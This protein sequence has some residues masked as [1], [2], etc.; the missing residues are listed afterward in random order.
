MNNGIILY[1]SKYGATK[2]YAQW[3]TEATG[4]DCREV[5]GTD[6]AS[7]TAYDT[8]ICCGGLYASGM[9][10]LSFLKKNWAAL[11]G[12]RIF[13]LAV[14]ASPYDEEAIAQCKAHN[15]KGELADLPLFYARGTWDM[16]KMTLIHRT[17]CR[18]LQKA[19][20]KQEA[21]EPWQKALLAAGEQ[22]CD[23]TDK[24]YLEPLLEA[25][26]A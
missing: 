19:V 24:A 9:A 1:Q 15:L 4:F 25:L 16:E 3:L 13:V 8:L 23:W 6:A 12:K 17:L 14:G 26:R 11:S 10:G 21:V 22:S 18:M 20:A 2:K 7:L 5:K